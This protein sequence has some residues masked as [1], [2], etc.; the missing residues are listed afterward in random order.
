[1]SI[2]DK[3]K[4]L[5]ED[6]ESGIKHCCGQT[7]CDDIE[8]DITQIKQAFTDEGYKYVTRAETELLDRAINGDLMT[9]QEWYDRF[10]GELM[11]I[12]VLWTEEIPKQLN[13][14]ALKVLEAAKKASGISD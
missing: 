12:S 5:L 9:G 7:G 11:G 10:K 13:P 6:D 8:A 14:Y 3:L 4:S 1:M 2:D